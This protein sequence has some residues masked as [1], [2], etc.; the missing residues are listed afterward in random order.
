MS[1]RSHI[2][3]K[4]SRLGSLLPKVG[5]R[6][7]SHT[8]PQVPKSHF[9]DL[10][11]HPLPY[12][13]K[14]P[15]QG[16]QNITYNSAVAKEL[17]I[18]ELFTDKSTRKSTFRIL[19]I[20]TL[21]Q[22]VLFYVSSKSL[23]DELDDTDEK[24]MELWGFYERRDISQTVMA[25]HIGQLKQQL[26]AAGLKPVTPSQALLVSQ[27]LLSF[28]RDQETGNLLIYVDPNSS[29][30]NLVPFSYE[31]DIQKIPKLDT[32]VEKTWNDYNQEN[33]GSREISK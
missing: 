27:H 19:A 5:F 11:N 20:V 21:L 2:L 10:N 16:P 32:V 28:A 23:L 17:S 3:G 13:F 30:Y 31:Y 6:Q 7:Q 18:G 22:V 12:A 26:L 33:K 4:P 15:R 29:I 24:L 9:Q 1:M 8:P 25:V 14:M